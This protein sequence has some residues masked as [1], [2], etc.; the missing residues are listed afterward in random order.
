[1]ESTN[2]NF[3]LSIIL[4]SIILYYTIIKKQ[5]S[6]YQ[7]SDLKIYDSI[8]KY[9]DNS[10]KIYEP[11]KINNDL[12]NDIFPV[13]E[14]LKNPDEKCNYKKKTIKS[15]SKCPLEDEDFETEFILDHLLTNGPERPPKPQQSIKKFNEDFFK[16]RGYTQIDSNDIYPDPVDRINSMELQGALTQT[17]DKTPKIWNV[18]DSLV[19]SDVNLYKEECNRKPIFDNIMYDG[20]KLQYGGTG[21]ELTRD[22]W[23]YAN[24]SQLNGGEIANELYPNDPDYLKQMRNFNIH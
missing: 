2:I 7:N 3:V 17:R 14:I 10:K 4:I 1:M 13:P 19:K 6:Y 22:D 20:W 8:E 24:E 23:K 12:N 11:H 16:F 9:S 5:P 21:M 18:Y 15:K